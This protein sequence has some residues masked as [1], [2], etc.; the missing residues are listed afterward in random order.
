[1]SNEYDLTR[2]GARDRPLKTIFIS[3]DTVSADRLST[4]GGT[5]CATPSL[6]LL[7]SESALFTNAFATDI[8]TQPSHTAVFT[9]SYGASTGII[10]HF[11]PPAQ[12]AAQVPWLPTLLR[13]RG[14]RTGA[15]DHLF[16]MKEWFERGYQDYMVPP[17][18]SRSPASVVNELAFPWLTENADDDFFLFLHYWDAHIPYVP[19]EPFRSRYTWESGKW[20][21]P[22]VMNQL[23]TRPSFPLFKKNLY[24]ALDRI[25]NLDYIAD[26]HYAEVAYLDHELGRLFG[27][28]SDL[29]ILDDCMIVIFGDHGEIMTEHDAWFDHAGL[30]DCVVHVP[31][32]IR[33]PEVEPCRVD[34]LVALIDI[35]PT[36]LELS[37]MGDHDAVAGCDGRSL[38]PVITGE[39]TDHRNVIMLSECTWQ[40][41]RG[42]R[43]KD[44]K[45]I[46][47]WD[48]GI[49]ERTG[50]ELYDIVA[51]PGE[52]HDVSAEH[53][54]VAA[55]MDAFMDGWL[56]AQHAG[57]ADPMDE[58]IDFGL[59]AVRRLDDFIE[60]ESK[61]ALS[62]AAADSPMIK[63][64][65]ERAMEPAIEPEM[66]AESIS[67]TQSVR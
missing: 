22:E 41:K 11:H 19:E 58:V 20:T 7:A 55:K 1:V 32:I 27:H 23:Q 14:C 4:L 50:V 25:P 31:L 56:D 44:W 16:V 9:G 66:E 42:M 17:G 60:E 15:V 54:D 35:M 21:D 12:L 24:D 52:Q 36:V 40:A 65:M 49:Y 61:N 51:D 6:D 18:R 53:P 59:P 64:A 45:Y 13:E 30:Y 67:M 43:T 63:A 3:L 57:R 48:P 33:A 26:L 47:C 34:S 5:R 46:R 29:G 28:L 37:G 8:P 38:L 62:A 2:S 10:S 39:V